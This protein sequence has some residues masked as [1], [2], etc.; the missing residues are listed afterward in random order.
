MKQFVGAGAGFHS[1]MDVPLEPMDHEPSSSII[2]FSYSFHWVPPR[3]YPPTNGNQHDSSIGSTAKF[4][5]PLGGQSHPPTPCY[6][7][8]RYPL[9]CLRG[10]LLLMLVPS[11]LLLPIYSYRRHGHFSAPLP[12]ILHTWCR[13]GDVFLDKPY[14]VFTRYCP[15]ALGSI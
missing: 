13:I 14:K 7:P 6:L 9:S 15:M 4:S 5:S 1:Y 8:P 10:R 2:D 12:V 3:R 11:C